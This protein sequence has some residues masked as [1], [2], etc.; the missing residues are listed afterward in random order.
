MKAS[1]NITKSKNAFKESSQINAKNF[2][3]HKKR[4]KPRY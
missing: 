2:S 1:N 3:I 4:F